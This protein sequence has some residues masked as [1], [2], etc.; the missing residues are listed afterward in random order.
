M[1][2]PDAVE[3]RA[4]ATCAAR[5]RLRPGAAPRAASIR[6]PGGPGGDRAMTLCAV[7]RGGAEM[8]A[9]AAG[10]RASPACTPIPQ[11]ARGR[12]DRAAAGRPAPDCHSEALAGA[13]RCMWLGYPAKSAWQGMVVNR[14]GSQKGRGQRGMGRDWEVAC[15]RCSSWRTA[16]PRGSRRARGRAARRKGGMAVADRARRAVISRQQ[17]SAARAARNRA[18]RRQGTRRGYGRGVA[19]AHGATEG[20]RQSRAGPKAGCVASGR[21]REGGAGG[22]YGWQQR[23]MRSA[24][25]ARTEKKRGAAAFA[26]RAPRK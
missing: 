17:P 25:R 13:A 5:G 18:S 16:R 9:G 11:P 3:R 24:G 1:A 14:R 20:A 8:G 21:Q 7:A 12:A 4:S 26:T 10:A 15:R 6:A 22:T 2:V 19:G 23:N